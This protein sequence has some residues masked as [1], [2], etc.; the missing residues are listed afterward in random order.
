MA[1][2]KKTRFDVHKH[3]T[4][5]LEIGLIASLLIFIIAMKADLPGKQNTVDFSNEKEIVNIQP[6]PRT[7]IKHNPPVPPTPQVMP[8]EPKDIPVNDPIIDN[9]D[10]E[11]IT[12]YK[13]IQLPK[14]KNDPNEQIFVAVEQ[15]PEIIGG[16][17]ALYDKLQYPERCKRAGIEGRVILQ[18]IVNIDGSVQDIEVMRGIGGGCDKAAVEAVRQITFKPGR[19]RGKPVRVRYSWPIVFDLQ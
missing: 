12:N 1:T 2:H 10:P 9:L 3:H 4:I 6:V 18:F 7:E 11:S 8:V 5:F 15:E 19:Q 14:I 17:K 16:Q 13:P